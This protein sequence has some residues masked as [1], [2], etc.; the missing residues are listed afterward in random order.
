MRRCLPVT[1]EKKTSDLLETS[2]IC[3]LS[4]AVGVLGFLLVWVIGMLAGFGR[5]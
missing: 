5:T 1:E 2:I 3:L 4:A